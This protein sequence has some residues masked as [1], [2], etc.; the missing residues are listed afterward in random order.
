MEARRFRVEAGASGVE[1]T[2]RAEV[3]WL[4]NALLIA[5]ESNL[6]APLSEADRLEELLALGSP[7]WMANRKMVAA[8]A[9][10]RPR[11]CGGSGSRL[12]AFRQRLRR[13]RLSL[14]SARARQIGQPLAIQVTPGETAVASLGGAA[15]PA[16]FNMRLAGVDLAGPGGTRIPA[17]AIDLR[18]LA[19][20]WPQM[21]KTPAGRGKVQV[22]PELL[23]TQDRHPAVCA[24]QGSTRQ[25]WDHGPRPGRRGLRD[26][27]G[28][29]AVLRRGRWAVH[30]GRG[31]HGPPVPTANPA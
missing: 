23:E 8:P 25:Y 29:T 12:C 4:V 22:V 18:G 30:G 28:R 6:D 14:F 10:R 21:D 2:F 15:T 1:L 20:C 3:A 11:W 19:C 9:P 26:I 5:P 16:P 24:P 31:T 27:P 13:T 7:E 17:T